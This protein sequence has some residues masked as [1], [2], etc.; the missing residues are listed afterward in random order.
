MKRY[1]LDPRKPPRMTA[2]EAKRLDKARVNYADIPRLSDEF[3]ARA[4]QARVAK[5][6]LT[7]RLDDDVL[8]WLKSFGKG[9]QTRINFILRA[10]MESRAR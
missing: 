2:T 1:R 6:Q 7:I 5:Q 9:Y 3:F 10:A 8:R 4:L